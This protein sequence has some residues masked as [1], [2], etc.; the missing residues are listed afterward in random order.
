MNYV[1]SSLLQI[2][3]LSIRD[4]VERLNEV[5]EFELCILT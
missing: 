4:T 1:K 2:I 3:R 5:I